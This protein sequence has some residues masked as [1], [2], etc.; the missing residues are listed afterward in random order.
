[1]SSSTRLLKAFS[2][3]LFPAICLVVVVMIAGSVWLNYVAARPAK[4]G[5]LVTPEKYGQ[6]ST[7]AAQVTNET[8]SNSDGTTARGWLL[9]GTPGM[10]AVILLHKYGADRSHVLNLGVKLNESTDFTILMPDMRGHGEEPPVQNSS[11]GGCEAEDTQSA[12]TFLRGLTS[13]NGISI[14]GKKF[15][16]YG[17]EMGAVTGLKIAGSDPEV[18]ALVLDSVPSAANGILS[19]AVASRYPFGSTASS[20]LA[21]IGSYI[22]YFDGCFAREAT[23]EMAKNVADRNVLLLA[24]IDTPDLQDATNRLAKCFPSSTM[25]ESKVDLSPSGYRIINASMEQSEAY[26]QRVID[27]FKTALATR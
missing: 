7:R 15:G 17:V 27:F 3:L 9:R 19:S 18:A 26:D 8:W 13:P 20:G 2:R 5:Y 1:M 23:C 4:A 25:V 14:V 10:P 11:F 22:Y 16:V 12:L 6:L 24:G 21:T